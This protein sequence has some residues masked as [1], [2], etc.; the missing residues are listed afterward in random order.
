MPTYRVVVGVALQRPLNH[1]GAGM[2]YEP[3]EFRKYLLE[4]DGPVDAR[5]EAC[6]WAACTSV[7]PVWASSAE[8][9]Y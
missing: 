4:A 1:K 9:V 8:Q 6:Q 3:D 2:P 5:L 7:M